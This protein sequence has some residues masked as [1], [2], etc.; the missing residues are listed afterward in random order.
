[1]RLTSSHRFKYDKLQVYKYTSSDRAIN[2]MTHQLLKH[3]RKCTKEFSFCPTS[4]NL[5]RSK[6]LFLMLTRTLNL[7]RCFCKLTL[8]RS[9]RY[10]KVLHITLKCSFQSKPGAGLANKLRNH[11]NGRGQAQTL[12]LCCV[13][14]RSMWLKNVNIIRRWFLRL[15][16]NS[17]STTRKW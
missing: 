17:S 12:L 10:L 7:V 1:M 14:C 2:Q 16:Q 11:F 6:L 5:V 8:T 3:M 15:I 4:C 9:H 13:F